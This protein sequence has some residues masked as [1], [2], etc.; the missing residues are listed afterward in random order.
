MMGI[1]HEKNQRISE[2]PVGHCDGLGPGDVHNGISLERGGLEGLVCVSDLYSR[3]VHLD[4][5]FAEY[6]GFLCRVDRIRCAFE[7]VR[8]G[9]E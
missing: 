4:R 9:G 6:A 5:L 3:R 7:T 8:R 2:K 1:R